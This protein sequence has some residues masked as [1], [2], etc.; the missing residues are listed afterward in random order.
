MIVRYFKGR[1]VLCDELSIMPEGNT[2]LTKES[3]K[4]DMLQVEYPENIFLGLGWYPS[5]G[6]EGIFQVRFYRIFCH[7]K[8]VFNSKNA[9]RTHFSSV[10]LRCGYWC[11]IPRD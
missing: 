5:F 6:L 3:L 8:A 1:R 2:E 10:L 4:E 7:R 11:S 9:T